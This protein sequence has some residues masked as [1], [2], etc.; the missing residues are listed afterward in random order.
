MNFLDDRY[1][2]QSKRLLFIDFT[3]YEIVYAAS[4]TWKQF[5]DVFYVVAHNF[6]LSLPIRQSVD[7]GAAAS[8]ARGHEALSA[9]GRREFSQR[10]KSSKAVSAR[11]KRSQREE[12]SHDPIAEHLTPSRKLLKIEMK[13]CY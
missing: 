3:Y 1:Y 6:G 5:C 13:R 2:A 4:V 11:E 12:R 10:E 8:F 7:R 9:C